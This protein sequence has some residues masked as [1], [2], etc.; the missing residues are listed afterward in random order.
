M[1]CSKGS[2]LY[3]DQY[4]RDYISQGRDCESSKAPTQDPHEGSISLLFPDNKDVSVMMSEMDVNAI[5]GT[6]KLYFREL[7]EPLFTDEFYPN[8][9]E[10]IG[11]HQRPQSCKRH[12]FTS[13]PTHCYP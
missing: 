12:L 3:S 13:P 9:A 11:E 7:P 4:G 1:S 10:G 5:A 2:S 6:L 8:F